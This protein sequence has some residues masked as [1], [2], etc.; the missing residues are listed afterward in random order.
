MSWLCKV[1]WR[2]CF[3]YYSLLCRCI[4]MNMY[5]GTHMFNL[6]KWMPLYRYI[7][8]HV[9]IYV[10]CVCTYIYVRVCTHSYTCVY[11]PIHICACIH[12]HTNIE[13]DR[14]MCG[15]VHFCMDIYKFFLC[16]P[17][18]IVCIYIS[19]INFLFQLILLNF[20]NISK[21]MYLYYLSSS[22]IFVEI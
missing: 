14:G 2:I 5:T 22:F 11:M 15:C 6:F 19:F 20:W 9:Y 13:R 4:H 7:C 16:V 8:A 18:Y 17:T 21:L 10:Y 3:L 1:D 12:I